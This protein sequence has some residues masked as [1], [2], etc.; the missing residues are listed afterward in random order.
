MLRSAF[1]FLELSGPKLSLSASTRDPC[2]R[3]PGVIIF[4]ADFSVVAVL[5][6]YALCTA[7][8]GLLEA[9]HNETPSAE[10]VSSPTSKLHSP[11]EPISEAELLADGLIE[12]V[13]SRRIKHFS[14]TL[15][16]TPKPLNCP[17]STSALR[18]ECLLLRRTLHPE[19]EALRCPN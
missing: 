5:A 2:C 7:R 16:Y 14:N 18:N 3:D 1:P 13:R 17:K 15:L 19:F 11:Y 6:F 9:L 12:P 4:G 8:A 10:P